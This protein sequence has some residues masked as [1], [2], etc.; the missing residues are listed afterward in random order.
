MANRVMK[1]QAALRFQKLY[2]NYPPGEG[3]LTYHTDLW[4]VVE[5]E[6]EKKSRSFLRWG[7]LYPRFRVIYTPSM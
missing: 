4:T 1:R 2:H 5:K 6:K 3:T 7:F